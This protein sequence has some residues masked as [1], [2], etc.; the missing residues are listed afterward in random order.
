[1]NPQNAPVHIQTT[2]APVVVLF[3]PSPTGYLHIGGARTALYNYL[4]AKKHGGKFILRIEDTDLERSTEQSIQAIIDGL[5]WL[6]L[7]WDE[8]PYFQTKRFDLY[9]QAI[10]ALVKEKKAY[11]CFCSQEALESKREQAQT[12]KIKYRYDRT[13]LHL[14]PE[15]IT[16]R[17][18]NKE[19]HVIRF[20]SSDEGSIEINDILKGTVTVACKEMDDL[21]IQRTDGSPTYNF[22]V[23]VDDVLMGI[24][25]VIRGDDH[26]NNTPRQI[27]LYRAMGCDVPLFAHLP[28]ILGDD[29]KRLSK[30]HGATSV[31]AYKEMGYLPDALINYLVRL[32]WGHGDEEIFCRESMIECFSFESCCSSASVFN[33]EKLNWLNGHYI[34]KSSPDTLAPL[35]KE[36]LASDGIHNIDDTQLIKAVRLN[37]EKAKTLKELADYIKIYFTNPPP[38]PEVI[39]N[40][41]NET[42]LPVIKRICEE[43]V[44]MSDTEHDT[45]HAVFNKVM[46]EFNL[47]LGKVA[48]PVRAAISGQK[49]SPG[50]FD[51]IQVFGKEESLK[52][53]QRH[54]QAK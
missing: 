37:L 30:R 35:I 34:R 52:R 50:A 11:P 24:T 31:M 6:G 21:I 12:N 7:R 17:L 10:D 53:I 49:V 36:F 29:K 18:A 39:K 26:L 5:N 28:M 22:T 51:L 47:K 14:D 16:Q 43:L 38:D 1:M 19:P 45:I 23:V 41:I 3:A 2:T 13:C 9:K 46:T 40:N 20:L 33:M 32:G 8:G 27:Q 15:A 25:H 48:G 4:F 42:T 44:Q 54:V